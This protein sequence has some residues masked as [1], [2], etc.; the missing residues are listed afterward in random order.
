MMDRDYYRALYPRDLLRAARELGVNP[1]MAVALVEAL[2][3]ALAALA[4]LEYT[5]EYVT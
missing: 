1:E 2:D 4:A 3:D 5:P